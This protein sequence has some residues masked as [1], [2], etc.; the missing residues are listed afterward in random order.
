MEDVNFDGCQD[1]YYMNDMGNVNASYI[2]WVWNPEK[3]CFEL[4]KELNSLAN[5]SVDKERQIIESW[6]RNSGNTRSQKYYKYFNGKLECIRSLEITYSDRQDYLKIICKD[7]RNGRLEIIIE[8]EA[9]ID[10]IFMQEKETETTKELFQKEKE[11]KEKADEFWKYFHD[12]D[13]PEK[14]W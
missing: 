13:Y 11:M 6:E 8:T 4:S 14:K 5:F 12:I 3:N 1:F 9:P 7:W 2:V 10:V